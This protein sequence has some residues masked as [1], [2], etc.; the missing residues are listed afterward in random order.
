M[1]WTKECFGSTATLGRAVLCVVMRP[2]QRQRRSARIRRHEWPV[3]LPPDFLAR[4]LE[5][6][7]M[8]H[9]AENYG[10][11]RAAGLGA[12]FLGDDR[13]LQAELG[14]VGVAALLPWE[15]CRAWCA[16]ATARC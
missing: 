3:L 13:A 7:H 12:G 6:V 10:V 14:E 2:G 15:A 4:I 1:R 5:R 8:H 9:P 11:E 16:G